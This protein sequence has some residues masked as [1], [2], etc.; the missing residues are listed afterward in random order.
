MNIYANIFSD[1]MGAPEDF[2][3]A[4]GAHFRQ[5]ADPA[6]PSNKVLRVRTVGSESEL[7]SLTS[8]LDSEYAGEGGYCEVGLRYYFEPIPRVSQPRY[9][10][11]ELRDGDG[12]ALFSLNFEA[13]EYSGGDGTTKIAIKHSDGRLV[14]GAILNAGRWYTVKLELYQGAEQRIRLALWEGAEMIA[15]TDAQVQDSEHTVRSLAILHYSHGIEGVSYFDDIFFALGDK[16]YSYHLPDE[17]DLTTRVYDFEDGIPSTRDFHVEM[18]LSDNGERILLDPATWT[19]VLQSE[20]FKRSRSLCEILLVLSGSGSYA[21]RGERIPFE[22]GSIFVSAPGVSRQIISSGGYKILSVSGIFEKLSFVKD[23]WVLSDNVYGEGRKLAELI[24][25][26]RF[27]KESYVQSL[28]NAYVEYLLLSFKAPEKNTTA[29]IYKVIERINQHFG[30]S[31]L[32]VGALLEESGYTRD[33]IRSE[34]IAVTKMTPKKYLDNL[35][36]K[37]A[38]SLIE[39]HG[40]SMSLSEIA[41]AC[42]IIDQSIFSRNFKKHFG[43]SPSQY[44]ESLKK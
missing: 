24:L 15:F 5:T 8:I 28:A 10:T 26:N 12:C 13:I 19:S 21:S 29:G 31:D 36:M 9:F 23:V 11:L 3:A 27:G 7:T 18:L 44:K 39:M 30:Q 38:K 22:A 34:F 41:E 20:H 4:L 33:Y 43:I 35:R 40:D 2:G 14:D 37:H 6:E 17:R 42:G 16:K 1:K 32:S 25:Y